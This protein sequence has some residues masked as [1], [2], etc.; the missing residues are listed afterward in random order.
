M[1]DTG[2]DN[3]TGTSKE[4]RKRSSSFNGLATKR[5]R[6]V[7]KG[8]LRKELFLKIKKN[9]KKMWPLSLRGK[10]KALVA[11]PLKK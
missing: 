10:G 3:S 6:G 11:G 5:E 8:Q 2:T 9:P 4:N 7:R 1:N